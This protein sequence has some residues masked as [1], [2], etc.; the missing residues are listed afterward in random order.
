M[1]LSFD[2]HRLAE[3]DGD[4]SGEPY[5]TDD[6]SWA[7]T[8]AMDAAKFRDPD[9]LRAR[10]LIGSMLA[11]P[12]EVLASP[13]LLDKVITLGADAPQYTTPGPTRSELLAAIADAGR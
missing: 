8:K 10:M 11:T 4:I 13:G 6:R 2:R 12:P 3:I 5:Q 1:T 7:I 9:V